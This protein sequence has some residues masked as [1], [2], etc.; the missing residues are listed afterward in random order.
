M[1]VILKN[2]SLVFQQAIVER[3]VDVEITPVQDRYMMEDGTTVSLN[4][5]AYATIDVNPSE[6]YKISCKLTGQLAIVIKNGDTVLEAFDI[7]D[8]P[9]TGGILTDSQMTM[10][11]NATTLTVSTRNPGTYPISIKKLVVS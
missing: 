2:T 3:W 9:G 8:F 10:P 6:Q 1:K 7:Y 5:S 11:A 4:D